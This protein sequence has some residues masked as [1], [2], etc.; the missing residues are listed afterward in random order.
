MTLQS[1][2]I[3]HLSVPPPLLLLRLLTL[4]NPAPTQ[5]LSALKRQKWVSLLRRSVH[6]HWVPWVCQ[7]KANLFLIRRKERV[8]EANHEAAA[9]VR[10]LSLRQ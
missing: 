2:S 4:R 1:R 10:H 6:S 7:S 3:A 9:R 8:K 5:H